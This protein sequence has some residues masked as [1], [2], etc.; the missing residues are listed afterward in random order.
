MVVPNYLY[1][2]NYDY[3]IV[4]PDGQYLKTNILSHN[5][6]G[7]EQ[8]YDKILDVLAKTDYTYGKVLNADCYVLDAQALWGKVLVKLKENPMY[9]V[10]KNGD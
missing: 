10:D 7:V 6:S 9:F 8:R 3:D 4:L 1:G 5:F 2:A